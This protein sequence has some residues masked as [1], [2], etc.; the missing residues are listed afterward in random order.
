M[1]HS[2]SHAS[3][4]APTFPRRSFFNWLSYALSGLAVVILGA[5]LLGFFLGLRKKSEE[6]V[7]LGALKDFMPDDPRDESAAPMRRVTFENPN[8]Q[9]WDG[10]S[11]K[12]EVFV[13]YEGLDEKAKDA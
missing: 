3:T 1:D 7:A 9:P 12:T 10:M 8:R 2:S 5:P 11:A 6:W 13:R 4:P